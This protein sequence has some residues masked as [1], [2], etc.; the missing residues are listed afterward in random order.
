MTRMGAMHRCHPLEGSH[1][2]THDEVVLAIEADVGYVCRSQVFDWVPTKDSPI[3]QRGVAAGILTDR[4]HTVYST[5][6]TIG[7]FEVA[8]A[9]FS[10]GFESGDLS[11]WDGS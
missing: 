1:G 6:P 3:R 2:W 10:D 11:L 4:N 8:D 9:I 7:A 5:P